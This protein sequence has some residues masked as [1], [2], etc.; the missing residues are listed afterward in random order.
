MSNSLRDQLLK[1]GL[2]DEKKA[3]EVE[4]SE[5][6]AHRKKKRKAKQKP[7]EERRAAVSA[8]PDSRKAAAD[9]L[10]ARAE[11]DR[12]LARARQIK[13]ERRALK[14][15]VRDIIERRRQPRKDG[16]I[17]YNFVDDGKVKHIYVTAKLRDALG[18]GRMDIVRSGKTHEVVEADV[19]E[20]L[21]ALDPKV[22]VPRRDN[23]IAEEEAAYA[24]HPIPDDLDW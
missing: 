14:M 8:A 1:S 11:K 23:R 21:R 19:A 6:Q 13:E 20:K 3:K 17:A 22:V 15:Q 10:R 18:A 9:A 16:E 24:D 5:R 7:K 12:E 2:V 4:Q